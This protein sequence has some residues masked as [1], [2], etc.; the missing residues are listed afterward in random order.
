MR[1]IFIAISYGAILAFILVACRRANDVVEYPL[2]LVS[3]SVSLL[4]SISTQMSTPT[5][6][7]TSTVPPTVVPEANATSEITTSSPAAKT[8][9]ST[10]FP[11][12]TSSPTLLPPL[13]TEQA[14]ERL[15]ELLQN[16]GGCELPCWWGINPGESTI[17][18]AQQIVSPLAGIFDFSFLSM[19]SAGSL[20]II[21]PVDDLDLHLYLAYYP[22]PSGNNVETLYISTRMLRYI[23][24]G[25]G[26]YVYRS[27]YDSEAYRQLLGKLAL[28]EMLSKLGIPSKITVRAIL[29]NPPSPQFLNVTLLYPERGIFALYTMNADTKYNIVSGCPSKSFVSLWLIPLEAGDNFREFL[30]LAGN[31]E[32]DWVEKPLEE[33]IS[34]SRNEFYGIF[35]DSN[36]TSC[37]ETPIEIWQQ[38]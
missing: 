21:Y 6:S 18:E 16:N 12:Y 15:L 2:L 1:R 25:D 37:I 17:Q 11:T 36:A 29:P 13:P 20:S 4:T 34:M 38:P 24:K 19:E 5:D 27:V 8:N 35:K 10:A 23:D 9:Q 33:A 28:S 26:D 22:F 14:Y 7:Y 3:P 30:S 31:W 32:G